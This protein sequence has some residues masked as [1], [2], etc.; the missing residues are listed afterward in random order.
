MITPIGSLASAPSFP[1]YIHLHTQ[2]QTHTYAVYKHVRTYTYVQACNPSQLTNIIW[3]THTYIYI[4]TVLFR[5]FASAVVTCTIHTIRNHRDKRR[6]TFR[7]CQPTSP[8][9]QPLP[10]IDV[11]AAGTIVRAG[12]RVRAW[13]IGRGCWSLTAYRVQFLPFIPFQPAREKRDE[14]KVSNHQ[15]TKSGT[16]LDPV[17]QP[18]PSP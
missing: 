15:T 14:K 9:K 1:I 10:R 6:R 7:Q 3:T 5:I 16:Q 4:H 18:Q 17:A 8:D 2:T 12:W 13:Q 11:F